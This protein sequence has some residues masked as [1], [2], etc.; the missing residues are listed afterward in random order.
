MGVGLHQAGLVEDRLRGRYGN[1]LCCA[2]D[3][4]DAVRGDKT[5]SQAS[6]VLV[7]AASYHPG[8]GFEPDLLGRVLRDGAGHLFSGDYPPEEALVDLGGGEHLFGPPLLSHVV[9]HSRRGVGIVYGP[10]A[11]KPEDDVAAREVKSVRTFVGL[12]LLSPHAA[13]LLCLPSEVEQGLG[14][15]VV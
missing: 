7:A 13:L 9:E 11:R 10:L 6:A 12:W 5:S 15:R 3:V 8:A 4:A 14:D 1:R 2:G